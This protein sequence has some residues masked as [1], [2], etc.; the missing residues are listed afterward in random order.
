MGQMRNKLNEKIIMKCNRSLRGSLGRV[1][2]RK[3]GGGLRLVWG[4]G[5]DGL[6]FYE[7][8]DGVLGYARLKN[9]NG[10]G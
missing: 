1:I 10:N 3:R 7:K 6:R 5:L 4:E 9:K 8:K 2:E